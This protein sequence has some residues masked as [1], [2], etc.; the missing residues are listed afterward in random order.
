MPTAKPVP[1]ALWPVPTSAYVDG[2]VP[3][4][5]VGT[6]CADGIFSCADGYSPSTPFLRPLVGQLSNNAITLFFLR[7]F[8]TLLR[9]S[10]Y[11]IWPRVYGT[12]GGVAGARSREST[13]WRRSE[14]RGQA[15]VGQSSACF[16]ASK[17]VRVSKKIE[18]INTRT[19]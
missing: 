16:A 8:G 2:D 19:V 18:K 9:S 3:T 4:V 12:E 13:I 5:V 7:P 17:V 11:T 6:D 1:T 14:P 15:V 10:F